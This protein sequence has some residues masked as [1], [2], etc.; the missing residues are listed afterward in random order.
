MGVKPTELLKSVHQLLPPTP[1]RVINQ[2]RSR[3]GQA[4]EFLLF[5]L[6]V[7]YVYPGYA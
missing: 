3:Q 2:T 4:Q 1:K 7:F 6:R 5:K